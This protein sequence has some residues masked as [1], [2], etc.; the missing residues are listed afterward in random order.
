MVVYVCV[1]GDLE[2]DMDSFTRYSRK[3]R[4][5]LIKAVTFICFIC[6]IYIPKETTSDNVEEGG[7]LR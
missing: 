2:D 3:I 7:Y 6:L 5:T 1:I 4:M